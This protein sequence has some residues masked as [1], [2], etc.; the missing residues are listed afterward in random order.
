MINK[1]FKR[2]ENLQI[3]N[4]YWSIEII[5]GKYDSFSKE[6]LESSSC[7]PAA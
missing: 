4:N 1:S 6:I 5:D 3:M 2:V 7:N